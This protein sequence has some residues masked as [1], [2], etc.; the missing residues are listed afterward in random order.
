MKIRYALMV[1]CCA[2]VLVAGGA[3]AKEILTFEKNFPTKMTQAKVYNELDRIRAI[4]VFMN[5]Y[6]AVS[7]Q[8]IYQGLTSIGVA[9]EDVLVF[10]KLMDSNSLFLTANADTYYFLS[11]INLEKGP[12]VVEI[13]PDVSG[14][15][16]DAWLRWIADFGTP[17]AD[18]AMGGKYLL[19]PDGYKGALPEGGYFIYTSKTNRIMMLGRAFI[20]EKPIEKVDQSIQSGLKIYAYVPGAFG[21]SVGAFWN[22]EESI[23]QPKSPKPTRFV[24]GSGVKINT[25]PPQDAT[26]FSMLDAVVQSEPASALD[27]EIAGQMA[28]IGIVKGKPFAPDDRLKRI[29]DEA[30]EF[31]DGASRTISF[32]PKMTEGFAYYPDDAT[33]YWT[34]SLFSSRY[35]SWAP[36]SMIAQNDVQPADKMGGYNINARIAMFYMAIDIGPHYLVTFLDQEGKI[37]DGAKTYK[38]TLPKDIPATQFWSMTLYDNTTRSMVVT[39]QKYPKAGSL[40]YPSE[41]AKANEDGSFTIYTGP[42]K[43]APIPAGN[44]IQTNPKEGWFGIVRLYGPKPSFFDKTW[45]PGNFEEVKQ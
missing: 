6:P 39:P 19:V 9:D 16:N 7:V 40:S 34:N 25:I 18:R 26:F 15:F 28:A 5:A 41:A 35:D 44:W 37:L 30:A 36:S 45:R 12:M 11:F 14:V 43:P 42:Q 31:A 10:S 3:N 17:G 32:N 24:E 21:S 29:L 4:D 33:S 13:P 20:N 8:A 38:I 27:P 22:K 23:A 1:G 2:L